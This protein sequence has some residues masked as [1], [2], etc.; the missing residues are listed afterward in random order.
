MKP[1]SIIFSIIITVFLFTISLL[2][3]Q[4][5]FTNQPQRNE[6]SISFSDSSTP[7][8]ETPIPSEKA[9]EV[10]SENPEIKKYILHLEP[11][12][13]K[14]FL[15]TEFTDGSQL[16]SHIK[17]ICPDFLEPKDINAL[18]LGI[19]LYSK[20]DMLMLIEDYSS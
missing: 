15:T 7:K 14:V 1:K 10:L 4:Y 19:E 3:L 9:T 13:D 5:H 18:T 11:E 8:S 6:N 12:S 16:V 20:E 2:I 17:S